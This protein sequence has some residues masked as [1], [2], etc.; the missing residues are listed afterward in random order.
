M[1]LR[2]DAVVVGA[3]VVGLALARTLAR[4]GE[5]VVV[6][7]AESH[8]GAHTSSRNSEVIHAGIYYAP[9]SLKARLCVRGRELLYAFCDEYGVE[10]RRVGKLIVACDEDEVG[11]LL[12]LQRRAAAN[13]VHDL[14]MLSAAEALELE[15]HVRASAALFSPSTGIV[16]SHGLMAALKQDAERHAA[17]I[18]LRTRCLG[19]RPVLGGFEVRYAGADEGALT[20][21]LLLNAAGLSAPGLARALA[22]PDPDTLPTA[23]Y[24]KGHYFSMRGPSPFRHLVYPAP[25]PHGLGIHVTLDL[26]GRARFGPD[27]CFCDGIDY[28]FD[29]SRAP[30]FLAA[31]RRYYPAIQPTQLAP[32]DVGVR[33]KLGPEQ[34]PA[35]D[36]LVHGPAQHG[37]AGLVNLFGIESPGLTAALALAEHVCALV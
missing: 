13:G 31:I 21:R 18:Q 30:A 29:E 32:G 7:E 35:S 1:T 37:Q 15:P 14:A 4:R 26:A 28:S 11:A 3:G 9:G 25:L 17:V 12:E 8:I 20:C 23:H 5:L 36:F 24:A 22:A 34:A 33:P 19:A 2:C 10:S 16:D 27:V 6:L